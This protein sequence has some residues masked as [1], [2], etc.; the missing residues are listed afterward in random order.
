[1]SKCPRER[2]LA[3]SKMFQNAKPNPFI[4]NLVK[5]CGCTKLGPGER[6]SCPYVFSSPKIGDIS[7][8]NISIGSTVKSPFFDRKRGCDDRS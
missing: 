1:M 8:Q 3:L 4:T 5:K 2:I 6:K 7:R